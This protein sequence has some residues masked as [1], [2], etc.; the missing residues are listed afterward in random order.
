LGDILHLQIVVSG[1]G[2]EGP[3]RGA[4]PG[5]GRLI[6]KEGLLA[7]LG[8]AFLDEYDANHPEG[9]VRAALAERLEAVIVAVHRKASEIWQPVVLDPEAFARHLATAVAATGNPDPT[10]A[11]E[12]LHGSDL[13]LACAAARD[14]GGAREVFVQKF[15]P[16]IAA[17]VRALDG[18]APFIDD[19]QQSL[20]DRLLVGEDGTPRLLKYG[21]RS[22]LATWVGVAAQRLALD[23]L[24]AEGARKRAA[25]RVADEP[26]PIELD[27][28]L[29][30]LRARYRDDFKAAI[31]AAIG[32]LPQRERTVIRLQAVGGLTL[33]KIGALLGADE[34][35]VSRWVKRARDTIL[36]ETQ[37]ELGARLGIR[38]AEVPSLVRLV[39]S[40]L[41]VSVA[42]LLG[43]EDGS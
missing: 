19:V 33:G 12:A 14:I 5:G 17:A 10:A 26:L 1:P 35:T 28:E 23:L 6:V 43:E 20:C 42:R 30:Y 16:P 21:G 18:G 8:N 41:D 7:S 32:R 40:Q 9:D 39:D 34:S 25:D 29:Q 27:P 13:Y 3:S 4:L 31:T 37:R 22:A 24:R 15:L 38:V 2:G 36:T 11:V